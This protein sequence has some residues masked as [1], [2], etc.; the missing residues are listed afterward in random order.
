MM[1]N[2]TEALL[3]QFQKIKVD[4]DNSFLTM[5]QLLKAQELNFQVMTIFPA[6]VFAVLVA[7]ISTASAKYI[8]RD[9]N[10]TRI[11]EQ[12][13]Q[14]LRELALSLVHSAPSVKHPTRRAHMVPALSRMHS[15]MHY[16]L[17]EPTA[18]Q[19]MMLTRAAT[20][21]S[22]FESYQEEKEEERIERADDLLQGHLIWL[23]DR[24]ILTL[25]PVVT[26]PALER[27]AVDLDILCHPRFSAWQKTFMLQQLYRS[28][29]CLPSGA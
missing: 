24:I 14:L 15:S 21:Q 26:K 18:G 1:G 12:C 23:T 22:L 20:S 10:P 5:E 17:I 29:V 8:F 27:L 19:R 11:Q 13:R 28:H 2:L 3:I 7:Y 6:F 4:T 9:R 25:K 16:N